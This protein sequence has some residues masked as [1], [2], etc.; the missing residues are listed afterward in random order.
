MADERGQMNAG[1]AL[2]LRL[3]SAVSI[4]VLVAVLPAIPASAHPGGVQAATDYRTRIDRIDPPVSGLRVRFIDEG[5]QLEL[6]NSTGQTVEVSGYQGEALL[7][8]RVDGVWQNARAPSLYVDQPSSSAKASADPAA[9]PSWQR[10]STISSARWHDHR[11]VWHGNPPPAVQTDP[12]HRHRIT[13]WSVPLRAGAQPVQILGTLEW[14]PPPNSGA[15]WVGI[16]LAAGAVAAFGLAAPSASRRTETAWTLALVVIAIVTGLAAA[17]Y[18]GVVAAYNAQPTAAGIASHLL[19]EILP[20]LTGLGTVAAG[21]ALLAR[22]TAANFAVA[23][24]GACV[25]LI[26]GLGD[27]AVFGHAVA[28]IPADG[29]WARLAVAA[30]LAGGLGLTG[31]GVLRLRRAGRGPAANRSSG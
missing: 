29:R 13:I 19:G 10:V 15:W 27:A 6:R 14:L 4:G 11:T 7:Q 24:S 3:V 17:G 5:A 9:P 28:P 30:V 2:V 1:M 8:V 23:L 22:R 16:M 31:A 21:I 20:I 25:A 18:A 12:G 26:A